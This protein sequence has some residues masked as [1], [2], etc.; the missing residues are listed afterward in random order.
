MNSL[1]APNLAR[2]FLYDTF[3]CLVHGKN[4]SYIFFIFIFFKNTP[5]ISHPI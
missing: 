4:P 5:Q 1:V 2:F 3:N